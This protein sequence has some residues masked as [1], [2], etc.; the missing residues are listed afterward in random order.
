MNYM[1]E[2]LLQGEEQGLAKENLRFRPART[3]NPY[4]EVFFKDFNKPIL[5][6]EPIDVNAYYRFG[7]IFGPLLGE[8]METYA[9]L[10][11]VLFDILAHFLSE[12]DLRSGLCQAEYYAQ[13][14]REDIAANV[15]GQKNAKRLACFD[16]REKRLVTAGLL[17]M[18]KVGTSM[19]L[20]A[21][22]LRE[23]Y[24]NSIVYLDARGVREL[25]VYVGTKQTPALLE[26]LEL[27]CDMFVPA[28]YDVK[29]F[30]ELHFG[31][32]D[33]LETMGIGN[34]MMY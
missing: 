23:L 31:L 8:D 10:R 9:E 6:R 16:R 3:A 34:V 4:R 21:Q 5:N 17:R 7:A 32:I 13:F 14:L 11:A 28:D 29:L 26:Q 19:R 1:W 27:L 24:P 20:F 18:Y 22:L 25:L 12:L 30:W 15:F 33:T 2:I